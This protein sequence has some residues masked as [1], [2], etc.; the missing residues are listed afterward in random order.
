M[1]FFSCAK[2]GLQTVFLTGLLAAAPLLYVL[3]QDAA[4]ALARVGGE[5]QKA[6]KTL[7][8]LQSESDIAKEIRGRINVAEARRLLAPVERMTV[9]ASIEHAAATFHMSK[10]TYTL[11]PEKDVHMGEET[12]ALSSIALGGEAPNDADIYGFMAQLNH[13]LPGRLR[14][15]DMEIERAGDTL[16][17]SNV[18]YKMTLE[19]LSNGAVKNLAGNP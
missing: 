10:F 4:A 13:A 8:Q 1:S 15:T 19:W 11:A 9:A 7:G 18:R 2:I 17:T 16:T 14:V 5:R 6:E 3:H 12:L